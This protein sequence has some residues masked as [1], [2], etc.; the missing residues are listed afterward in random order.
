MSIVFQWSGLPS[1]QRTSR[2]CPR[3][4]R[5]VGWNSPLTTRMFFSKQ[6]GAA[7]RKETVQLYLVTGTV[8]V[9][10]APPVQHTIMGA[11]AMICENA[12]EVHRVAVTSNC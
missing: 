12:K 3:L 5:R 1:G 6:S 10:G 11:L 4:T 7:L 2:M 8:G 9:S